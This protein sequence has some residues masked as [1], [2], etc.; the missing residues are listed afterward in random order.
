MIILGK[1]YHERKVHLKYLPFKCIKDNCDLAFASKS[2]L[3]YH[4]NNQHQ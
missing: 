2:A 1:T 3:K 4:L